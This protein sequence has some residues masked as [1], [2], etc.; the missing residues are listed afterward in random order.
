MRD[1]TYLETA[2]GTTFKLLITE[3]TR[4]FCRSHRNG[5]RRPRLDEYII[6]ELGIKIAG[7]NQGCHH[8]SVVLVGEITSELESAATSVGR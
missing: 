3:N 6:K 8:M 1:M 7:I 5:K 2:N 4:D